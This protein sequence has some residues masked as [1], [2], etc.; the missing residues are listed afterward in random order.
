MTR[1]KTYDAATKETRIPLYPRKTV[2]PVCEPAVEG[3]VTAS[4]TVRWTNVRATIT[5][6]SEALVTGSNERDR[7]TREKVLEVRKHPRIQ[8]TLD[9]LLGFQPGDTMQATVLGAFELHGVSR[10]IQAVVKGW[11]EPLGLRVQAQWEFPAEALTKEYAMSKM[12]LGMGVTLGRW[13]TVHMGIDMILK[14]SS[15]R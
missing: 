5:V 3:E 12:A 6:K 15:A 1:Q 7:F 10:P 2:R 8:F 4:D 9:S 13:K 14:P 11:R